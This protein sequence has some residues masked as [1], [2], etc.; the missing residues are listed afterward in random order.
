MGES[1]QQIDIPVKFHAE[2]SPSL[3]V[4]SGFMAEIDVDA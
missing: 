2:A 1:R 3:F 4:W